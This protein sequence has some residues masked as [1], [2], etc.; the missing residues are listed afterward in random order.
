[1]SSYLESLIARG[2]NYDGDTVYDREGKGY[3][4][5]QMD[6]PEMDSAN[7]ENSRQALSALVRDGGQVQPTGQHDKYGRE[8]TDLV[9][10]DGDSL[11]FAMIQGGLAAPTGF[12]DRDHQFAEVSGNVRQ[13]LGLSRTENDVVNAYSQQRKADRSLIHDIAAA[14]NGYRDTR[15][16]FDRS[17]DRGVDE[18]KMSLGGAINYLGDRFDSD[19]M[20]D[21]GR[22]MFE[23]ADREARISGREIESFD[24]IEGL[25]DAM[26]Y[27]LETLGE[28]LPGFAIDA[29]A[30]LATGGASLV[31]TAARR[32][33]TKAALSRSAAMGSG[34][35]AGVQSGGSMEAQL[36]MQGSEDNPFA[37]I[38]Q[39]TTSAAMTALPVGAVLDRVLGK[40]G[41]DTVKRKVGE[42]IIEG[43]KSAGVGAS[44][45]MPT[46]AVESMSSQ[47]IESLALNKSP[48]L[49]YR[50]I[51]DDALRGALGGAVFAGGADATVSGVDAAYHAATARAATDKGGREVD[52]N[53][54]IVDP[55]TGEMVPLETVEKVTKQSTDDRTVGAGAMASTSSADLPNLNSGEF[56]RANKLITGSDSALTAGGKLLPPSKIRGLIERTKLGASDTPLTEDDVVRFLSDYRQNG[57]FALDSSFDYRKQF[58][59]LQTEVIPQF[60]DEHGESMTTE[61]R[62]EMVDIEREMSQAIK[63]PDKEGGEGV[64]YRY[65]EAANKLQGLIKDVSKGEDYMSQHDRQLRSTRFNWEQ[66]YKRAYLEQETKRIQDGDFKPGRHSGEDSVLAQ[67]AAAK[68]QE[69]AVTNTA[70]RSQAQRDLDA[71]NAQM[72]EFT[73]GLT[74]K[75]GEKG[76]ANVMGMKDTASVPEKARPAL[77][78]LL[79]ARDQLQE[80]V[81]KA[82]EAVENTKGKLDDEAEESVGITDALRKI[83]KHFQSETGTRSSE[84]LDAANMLDSA[85]QI[86]SEAK[87]QRDKTSQ[88]PPKGGWPPEELTKVER[89]NQAENN[90]LQFWNADSPAEARSKITEYTEYLLE[91][92]DV[93]ADDVRKVMQ[94]ESSIKGQMDELGAEDSGLDGMDYEST[95]ITDDSDAT[96]GYRE[97]VASDYNSLE[98]LEGLGLE[99]VEDIRVRVAEPQSSEKEAGAIQDLEITPARAETLYTTDK[100]VAEQERRS[101]YSPKGTGISSM[102]GA[103]RYIAPDLIQT[104]NQKMAEGDTAAAVSLLQ[105]N[106][107]LHRP[108]TKR[109]HKVDQLIRKSKSNLI[110]YRKARKQINKDAEEK[111]TYL[112]EKL[113]RDREAFQDKRSDKGVMMQV[114]VE[115]NGTVSME[116][117]ELDGWAITQLGAELEGIDLENTRW[118]ADETADYMEQLEQAFLAGIQVIMGEGVNHNGVDYFGDVDVSLIDERAA[119]SRIEGLDVVT[120]GDVQRH[121]FN[122]QRSQSKHNRTKV[123]VFGDKGGKRMEPDERIALVEKSWEAAI[124]GGKKPFDLHHDDW[125]KFTSLAYRL[126]RMRIENGVDT[127]LTSAQ[128][129]AKIVGGELDLDSTEYLPD[130]VNPDT[131]VTGELYS[132]MES[133][134]AEALG[135]E[136][137]G[138]EHDKRYRLT[139]ARGKQK[140]K[141]PKQA[142]QLSAGFTGDSSAKR[143]TLDIAGQLDAA[144][145]ALAGIRSRLARLERGDTEREQPTARYKPTEQELKAGTSKAPKLEAKAPAP[146]TA[147]RKAD[148]QA[149]EQEL[150]RQIHYLSSLEAAHQAVDS[151]IAKVTDTGKGDARH[152]LEAQIRVLDN[153]IKQVKVQAKKSLPTVARAEPE[154]PIKIDDTPVEHKPLKWP[155]E[156]KVPSLKRL[157][158]QLKAAKRAKNPEQIAEWEKEIA[159]REAFTAEVASEAMSIKNLV[160]A[161]ERAEREPKEDTKTYT[162]E[163]GPGKAIRPYIPEREK[164]KAPTH[165]KEVDTSKNEHFPRDM[166]TK[167]KED[168][169]AHDKWQ[170][171]AKDSELLRSQIT[172]T[173]VEALTSKRDELQRKL[174]ALDNTQPVR[175][176]GSHMPVDA[177]RD[178][179]D[180]ELGK[181]APESRGDKIKRERAIVKAFRRKGHARAPLAKFVRSLLTRIEAVHPEMHGQLKT[182]LKEREVRVQSF[183][184]NLNTLFDDSPTAVKRLQ[185]G[186]EAMSEGRDT[187][188]GRKVKAYIDKIED[189]LASKDPSYHKTGKAP[190]VVDFAKVAN[191][192]AGF[193]SILS[194]GGIKDPEQFANEIVESRGI[195]ELNYAPT[196]NPANRKNQELE[197]VLKKLR[198]G[199]Y[200]MED[201]P[202]ILTR[203]TYS[204]VNRAEW[205]DSFGGYDGD[206]WKPTGQMDEFMQEVH[207]GNREEVVKLLKGATG[208]LHLHHSKILRTANAVGMAFQ[209]ATVLLFSAVA[210]IPELGVMYSRAREINS[211]PGDTRKALS[212]QGRKE[213]YKFAADYGIAVDQTIKHT[214]TSLYGLDELTVG[215][216]N[217]KVAETVFKYNG[218]ERL[219]HF[220]RVMAAE[221]GKRIINDHAIKARSGNRRSERMLA[222]LG[223]EADTVLLHR[224]N[225]DP[226]SEAGKEFGL[227][228]GRF[229]NESVTNP[230][231]G[232]LPLIASDPRFVLLTSLK[233]FFYGFYDN[234]HKSLWKEYKSRKAEGSNA[235]EALSPVVIAAATMLPLAAFAEMLRE[236][237]KD[238]TNEREQDWATWLRRTATATGGLGPFQAAQSAYDATGYGRNFLV[239]LAGPSADFLVNDVI[240]GEFATKRPA[241]LLPVANQL[242]WMRNPIN[243][244]WRDALRDSD[245]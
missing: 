95:G 241:R 44:V 77:A 169:A 173:K 23:E 85:E 156:K 234:V 97:R 120:W 208:R 109:Q 16:T 201:A 237:V 205:S 239:S 142:K 198:E 184:T 243:Q 240:T 64:S 135:Q 17:L 13:A 151:E 177:K 32:T 46:S 180:P 43:F 3:R 111:N 170:N 175:E 163:P 99:G 66:S 182:Y 226:N 47:L 164:P 9:D 131:A 80:Q 186:Y 172:Q 14:G 194:E 203:Y 167:Q 229:V 67:I 27:G 214:L 216:F 171:K 185:R 213:M 21:Y 104:I 143:P 121:K 60:M 68:Q 191:D 107:L 242:P 116:S 37:P 158:A 110:G 39:G 92:M 112:N 63:E 103:V 238:P 51:V 94:P 10:E 178:A 1:M 28:A 45:E 123:R 119:I 153:T 48:E 74:E 188:S 33:A 130:V 59:I 141:E 202:T 179:T 15:G 86:F 24:E 8:L 165:G 190:I 36:E 174:D 220:N 82:Q 2:E 159:E 108:G 176:D 139:K 231:A 227:A 224:M 140:A 155:E 236:L 221:I 187:P 228:V 152:D 232:Q 25:D 207:P 235:A 52:E 93:T 197:P 181:P 138:F 12:S 65:R 129:H 137:Q 189:Y 79:Q 69:P 196:G 192:K 100:S 98:M 29:T 113:G 244:T 78:K 145:V 57:R 4:L 87:A 50:T 34:F 88:Q 49:E 30:A 81:A 20:R 200:M 154:P 11:S 75:Y 31:G 105:K 71:A 206:T 56:S 84:L 18:L 38:F 233:K 124:N 61:Q 195:S 183:I 54:N 210:S 157:Q 117:Q 126:E 55:E 90:V 83:A 40:I 132:G 199:G 115:K 73:A 245:Y 193:V 41:D 35:S 58:D 160:A 62:K 114:P 230:H 225:P 150:T 70:G 101:T 168:T 162:G 42:S 125:K 53:N 215:R 209:T 96:K 106:G 19:I 204:A 89:L 211:L 222:E 133:L 128:A 122:A 134:D 118:E 219:T 166:P 22:E 76:A 161:L 146:D 217:E 136:E 72:D 127:K 148:L 223:I 102:K 218:Q 147:T 26:T 149:R 7:G 91:Q 5:T 144:K 6:T 212:K